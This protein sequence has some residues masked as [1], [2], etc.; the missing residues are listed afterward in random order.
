[1][2]WSKCLTVF[3]LENETLVSS[4][5]N[6]AQHKIFI[7]FLHIDESSVRWSFFVVW[8]INK[9]IL[10]MNNE[11][12]TR[13]VRHKLTMVQRT[14]WTAVCNWRGSIT[15]RFYATDGLHIH[16]WCQQL[17]FSNIEWKMHENS[18]QAHV[19]MTRPCRQ[20]NNILIALLMKY[21]LQD[22][23]HSKR[24]PKKTVRYDWISSV[25]PNHS[26]TLSCSQ[27]QWLEGNINKW[28]DYSV[29]VHLFVWINVTKYPHGPQFCR[30]HGSQYTTWFVGIIILSL[31]GLDYWTL[32][33][34]HSQIIYY[35][36]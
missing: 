10:H 36:I 31:S 4:Q 22:T 16:C 32:R 30:I 18:I 1:M 5:S 15:H 7:H 27:G 12:R 26:S 2:W 9:S 8:A 34:C 17:M 23:R 33:L 35:N 14:K 11:H 20:S 25:L 24:Y 3:A 28:T 6:H 19:G 29:H 21:I 13:G